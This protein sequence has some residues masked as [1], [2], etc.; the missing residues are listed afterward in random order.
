MDQFYWGEQVY[1]LGVGNKAIPQKKLTAN[2]LAEAILE[3]T[4]NKVIRQN[5]ETLGQKIREE[6]GIKNAIAI[7]E[8]VARS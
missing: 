2:K 7:I 5:A 6:D 8:S 3:V 4:T 1:A